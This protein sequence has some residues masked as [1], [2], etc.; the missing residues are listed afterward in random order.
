VSR[1][2]FWDL[3]GALAERGVTVLV[4]THYMDEAEHCH[5][6]A[7]IHRGQMV[8]LGSASELK[9][10]FADRPILEVQSARPVET[11]A[12]LER[13]PDIEKTSIFG[14]TVHAVLR[15]AGVD[16]AQVKAALEAQ[17]LPVVAVNIVTPS[18]E[19]VFLDVVERREQH[20]GGGQ[21]A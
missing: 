5:R 21:A 4:T 9:G 16:L 7:I 3:I 8:A 20:A 1:R 15:H 10:V 6:L 18:L 13:L 2:Q 12:A 11:M 14:T 19:D 17:G